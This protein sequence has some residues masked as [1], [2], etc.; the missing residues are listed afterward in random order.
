M[1]LGK[2]K[3]VKTQFLKV[4]NFHSFNFSS[5]L[6]QKGDLYQ[7]GPIQV[8]TKLCKMVVAL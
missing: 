7:L 1:E 3:R 8:V 2:D 4:L 5:T 6:H